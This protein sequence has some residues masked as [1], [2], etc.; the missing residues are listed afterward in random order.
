MPGLP[1]LRVASPN[2]LPPLGP[3]ETN[4]ITLLL[5]PPA[6]LDLIP[7][8]GAIL[9]DGGN[10]SLNVPFQFRALSEAKGDLF[11]RVVDELTYYAEGAP[12]VT[13]ATVTL[14]DPSGAAESIMKTA[15]INV[16]LVTLMD[17]TVMPEPLTVIVV[18][19]VTKFAPVSVTGTLVP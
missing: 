16:P 2:P 5:S 11:V 12:L 6:D 19:P 17:V 4:M 1:W 18:A 14:R 9:I 10:V 3:N 15:L 13:N 8:D 7:F